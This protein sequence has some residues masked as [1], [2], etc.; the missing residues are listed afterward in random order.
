[1]EIKEE[2]QKKE[3]IM[4]KQIKGLENQVAEKT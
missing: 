2:F 3:E 1:M 4:K